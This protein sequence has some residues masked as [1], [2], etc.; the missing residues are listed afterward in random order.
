MGKTILQEL[1]CKHFSSVEMP[2]K[3]L[4][5]FIKDNFKKEQR[6]GEPAAAYHCTTEVFASLPAGEQL[7][8]QQMN[9]ERM[10]P[11]S[12]QFAQDL[13]AKEEQALQREL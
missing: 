8:L 1:L 9:E 3:V 6:D 10:Q 11:I 12:E 2:K 5:R 13:A 4:D 7:A